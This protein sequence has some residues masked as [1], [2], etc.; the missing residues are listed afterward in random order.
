LL[1]MV[2]YSVTDYVLSMNFMY[3][4]DVG[5]DQIRLVDGIMKW[6]SRVTSLGEE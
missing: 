6:T 1:G 5:G 4:E 3:T 2:V